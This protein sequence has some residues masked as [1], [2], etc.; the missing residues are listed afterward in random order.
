MNERWLTSEPHVVTRCDERIEFRPTALGADITFSL[1]A[2]VG[3]G[4]LSMAGFFYWVGRGSPVGPV[5]G[6]LLALVAAVHS[7][8][9]VR[10]RRLEEVPLVIE[11]DGR[12]CYGERELCPTAS[13]Q[14]V[15]LKRV[16]SG[17]HY[18]YNVS[19]VLTAGGEVKLPSPH[20]TGF[21]YPEP[22]CWFAVQLAKALQVDLVERG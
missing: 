7:W 11:N 20:F 10:A 1:F 16:P 8:Q 4:A 22:A 13:V 6:T 15:Q 17:E 3:L 12:V 18:N 2:L 21:L 9:A 19:V 14:A 5:F